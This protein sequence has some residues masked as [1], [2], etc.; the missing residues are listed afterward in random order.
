MPVCRKTALVVAIVAIAGCSG[1]SPDDTGVSSSAVTVC[2]QDTVHGMDISHYDGTID[3]PTAHSSGI[4]FAFA[5]A[6]ESTNYVDPTFSTN[7]A[8]ML[9]AGVVRGAYHFFHADV[10]PVAQ[11]NFVVQTVGALGPNDLPIALDLETTNGQSPSVI[12]AN[13]LTF[14]QTVTMLTGR[15]AAIYS[16][17]SFIDMIGNPAGL[18]TYTLWIAN[19]GVSCPDVPAPW[20]NWTFWQH[21]DTGTVP[22]VSGMGSV[23]LDTF[24]G[25]LSQLMGMGADAGGPTDSGTG[26]GDAALDSGT[27]PRDSG[28]DAMVLPQDAGPG[29]DAGIADASGTGP[30]AGPPP[31]SSSGCGCTTAP[32]GGG[33]SAVS[34]AGLVVLAASVRRARRRRSS[35]GAGA[36]PP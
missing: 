33:A 30:Q 14:L 15:T 11:A 20:S 4:A 2:G 18:Q 27:T 10:D 31:S 23:D 5:K 25:T 19:W 13:A 22:G 34:L 35:P 1:S 16:S 32:R 6:T 3:W 7:W 17:P 36:P 9:A 24:N 28:S 26:G 8:G 12:A 21:T 29:R